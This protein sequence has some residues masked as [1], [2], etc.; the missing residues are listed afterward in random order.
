MEFIRI[1]GL[2]I[3][4]AVAYGIVHDQ[5]TVRVCLEYY[6]IAH[7]PLFGTTSP[8]MIAI[9]WGIIATWWAG[10]MVG[11]PLALASRCGSWPKLSAAMLLRSI[12]SLL[13]LMA[14]ISFTAAIATW[15]SARLGAVEL[16]GGLAYVIV[17]DRHARFMAARH[18]H[19]T[20][21]AVGFLGGIGLIIRVIF[22]RRGMKANSASISV[23]IAPLCS[24]GTTHAPTLRKD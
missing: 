12:I 15:I 22:R 1:I 19:L 14:A 7:P 6:T 2:S 5:I 4:A 8:T 21:Y 10:L 11:L 17:P 9:G 24:E 20:S 3:L 13:L 18:S 16:R 23:G